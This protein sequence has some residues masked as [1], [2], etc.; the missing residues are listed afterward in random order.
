M[1]ERE[2]IRV[3]AA[4]GCR[5][6]VFRQVK[7]CTGKNEGTT[8]TSPLLPVTKLNGWVKVNRIS[9]GKKRLT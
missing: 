7:I 6:D 9:R 5:V 2:Y 3:K 8:R 1:L 4:V